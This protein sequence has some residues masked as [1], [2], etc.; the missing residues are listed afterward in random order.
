MKNKT[1]INESFM[2]DIGFENIRS[3]LSLHTSCQENINYFN[4]LT[5]ISDKDFLVEKILFTDEL[6]KSLIRKETPLSTKLGD[7]SMIILSL[8]KKESILEISAFEE[9]RSMVKYYF[10]MRK[11]FKG[12]QFKLW[13]GKISPIDSPRDILNRIDKIIDK[14]LNIRKNA[15]KE[16]G[17]II[18]SINKIEANI[19]TKIKSELKKYSKLGFL[20]DNKIVFRSGKVML[21]VN[22]SNK[23]KV[24][25]IVDGFSATR[26]TCFIQPIS[27]VELTNKLNEL[28]TNKNKE[29]IK[30]LKNLT[31]EIS[32]CQ[33]QL[34]TIY[35]LIKFYDKHLTKALIA[36]KIDAIKPK[37]SKRLILKNAINPIF[38]L[39]NKKYVPLNIS[40]DSGDKTI[41]ISGPNSGGKTVVIKSIGLYSVMAQCGLYIPALNAELPIFKTFLSDIGDKQ[42]IQDDLSTFSAHMKSISTI[43]KKSNKNSLVIID[44]MGTGT[45]PDIGSSLSISILQKLTQKGAL[46]LCTTHLNPLKIWAD[47]NE[48]SKNACME[49]DNDKIEPTYIFKLGSPGSSY[50][51]EIAQRMGIDKNI[52]DS[53]SQNLNHESFK[54]ENLLKQISN[55]H[56]ESEEKLNNAKKKDQEIDLKEKNLEKNEE[57]LNN[58]IAKFKDANLDESNNLLL[59]YRK[60]IESIIENIKMNDASK[61]SIKEAKEYL[62]KNLSDINRKKKVRETIYNEELSIGEYVYINKF[63]S[64]GTIIRID[65]KTKKIKVDVNN[66]KVT[67]NISDINKTT[68]KN[69]KE[70]HNIMGKYNITPLE[71]LRIDIRGKR[72]HEAIFEIDQFLDKA[73]LTN[74]K[75]V[76]I[77]HGKGTGALQE[78][79]HKH[80]KTLKFI[81]KFNFAPIDQGGSGITIVEF[82]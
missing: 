63:K 50:G 7:L 68:D 71:A 73:L 19:E 74:H 39:I 75:N 3:W 20:K 49:F 47:E 18:S 55:N 16:L 82:L 23:N 1:F 38:T 21:A 14:K 9:I 17:Q 27:L 42:S 43:I 69:K 8:K 54:M 78:A 25:G 15:S 11:K 59:S 58:K 26:Q 34:H 24:K 4:Q 31:L 67:V 52:I 33:Y 56:K 57:K 76:D 5:P 41:I 72:V 12:K 2:Q 53:A 66:K 61:E 65:E 44:E 28:E 80:L 62:S 48:N 29:I 6:L 36:Y 46:N 64:T 32:P 35:D 45:D 22:S 40:L 81:D 79:V 10:N 30:I 51:I 13:R 60:K 37:F 70:Y 77:L